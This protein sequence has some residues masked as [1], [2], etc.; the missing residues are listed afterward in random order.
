MTL[1]YIIGCGLALAMLGLAS[2]KENDWLEVSNNKALVIPSTLEDLQAILDN[3]S[4]MN[5]G[6]P[7]FGLLGTDNLIIPNMTSLNSITEREANTY[8][9]QKELYPAY[10]QI[11]D[12]NKPYELV[13]YANIVLDGLDRPDVAENR[14]QAAYRQIKGSALFFRAMAF[15]QL[16]QL[17][18][19]AYNAATAASDLGLPLRL[20]SDVNLVVKRATVSETYETILQDLTDALPLLP[21]KSPYLTRPSKVSATALL[22][23]IYLA[24]ED[25]A[26]ALLYADETLKIQAALLD[27]NTLSNTG[28]YPFPPLINGGSENPEIIFYARG[29][30]YSSIRAYS[31]T[32]AVDSNLLRL[33]EASDL[34]KSLF[35]EQRNGYYRFKGTYS[36]AIAQ[37]FSGIGVNEVLLIRAECYARLDQ[38]AAALADLRT[39]LIKRYTPEGYQSL[40]L[41]DSTDLLKIILTERR[42]ELP[43][44]GQLRWEDLRRLNQDQRFA[45]SLERN[46]EGEHYLLEPGSPRYVLP[47]PDY[48]LDLNPMPQ[49]ER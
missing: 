8:L 43:F 2:C 29:I 41:N 18:C 48:E 47:I 38:P 45:K 40:Q 10:P 13:A 1:R 21:E 5:D 30:S 6:Y 25:Y 28:L 34:R 32:S 33:Y 31:S 17:F 12:W 39:L 42:K 27:F 3:T 35:F 9:W 7:V 14:D 19:N 46:M 36:G 16:A 11:S 20:S 44:T 24:M 15:Y 37:L 49:N 23:K 4:A 26:N 22:A